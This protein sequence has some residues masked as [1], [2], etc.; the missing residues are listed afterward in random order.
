MKELDLHLK[1]AHNLPVFKGVGLISDLQRRFYNR[2]ARDTQWLKIPLDGK[3]Y[4]LCLDPIQV[5]DRTLLFQP[6]FWEWWERKRI[7][8]VLKNGDVFLDIGSNIGGYSIIMSSKVGESGKILAFECNPENLLKLQDHITVNNIKNVKII[9][10]GVSDRTEFLPMRT[11]SINMGAS[12]FI[13]TIH[14][15]LTKDCAPVDWPQDFTPPIKCRPLLDILK[16]QKVTTIKAMK[17]DIEGYE[18]KVLKK[19]FDT[20]D[21]SLYPDYIMVERKEIFIP[22][23]GGDV[24]Q[25]IRQ[26]GYIVDWPSH[27]ENYWCKLK[28]SREEKA[29]GSH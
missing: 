4:W 29:W 9:S 24:L 2:K 26:A 11:G 16:E 14:E 6:Q 20:A 7:S 28:K 8:K 17:I 5:V 21:E 12:T 25:V 15:P 10:E 18:Y 22:H 19:F 13:K 23:A 3:Q 1:L 27:N